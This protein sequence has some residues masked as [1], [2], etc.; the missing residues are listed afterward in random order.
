MKTKRDSSLL[1]IGGI[2]ARSKFWKARDV[3]RE[4][5]RMR[6][7][8]LLYALTQHRPQSPPLLLLLLLLLATHY[9]TLLGSHRLVRV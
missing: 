7:R 8:G 3:F 6:W 4:M 9:I 1:L 5:I 2:I